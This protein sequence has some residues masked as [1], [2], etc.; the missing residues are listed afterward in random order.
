MSPHTLEFYI[1]S[2]ISR[3]LLTSGNR[4][5]CVSLMHQEQAP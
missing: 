2:F 5:D 3:E 1:W 4:A